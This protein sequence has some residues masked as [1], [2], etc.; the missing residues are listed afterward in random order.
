[1][2][3]AFIT[4][5]DFFH[6]KFVTKSSSNCRVTAKFCP[7]LVETPYSGGVNNPKTYIF[8]ELGCNFLIHW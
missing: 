6:K 4:I 2:N 5:K 3:N 7:M 8:D 1:M